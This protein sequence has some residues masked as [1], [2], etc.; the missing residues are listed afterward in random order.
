MKQNVRSDLRQESSGK[1]ERKD[2]QEGSEISNICF[3][4]GGTD[5]KTGGRA[6]VGC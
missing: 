1:S 3:G 2:L 5:L 6:G 4:D